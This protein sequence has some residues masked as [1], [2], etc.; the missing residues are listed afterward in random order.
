MKRT[1]FLSISFFLLI[2]CNSKEDKIKTIIDNSYFGIYNIKKMKEIDKLEEDIFSLPVHYTIVQKYSHK[3]KKDNE[4]E[5]TRYI[6]KTYDGAYRIFFLID[7]T[8]QKII[9]K[10]SGFKEFFAPIARNIFG[11]KIDINTFKGDNLMELM[12]Y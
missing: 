10:S 3:V 9:D 12:T 7:L 5:I 6:Y 4:Y 11:D 8:N 2:S 1:I